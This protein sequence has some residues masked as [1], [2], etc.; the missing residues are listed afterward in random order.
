MAKLFVSIPCLAL[1]GCEEVERNPESQEHLNVLWVNSDRA[2]AE[3]LRDRETLQ[4]S[5]SAIKSDGVRKVQIDPYG[6]VIPKGG[7]SFVPQL[8][9]DFFFAIVVVGNNDIRR[10][11]VID[12]SD[13]HP[14]MGS[15]EFAPVPTDLCAQ[16]EPE[17]VLIRLLLQAKL[18]EI[19]DERLGMVKQIDYLKPG[20]P[21]DDVS[22]LGKRHDS[23]YA[24][25]PSWAA[26]LLGIDAIG[27]HPNAVQTHFAT[28]NG[29]E[30]AKYKSGDNPWC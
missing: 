29:W 30:G 12:E 13:V 25:S 22:K 10:N 15:K 26:E 23:V 24:T 4:I 14:R 28:G 16:I 20:G 5:N 8:L 11:L 3:L 18:C 2:F 6:K 19:I 27:S 21:C 1:G 9:A 17:V 7:V